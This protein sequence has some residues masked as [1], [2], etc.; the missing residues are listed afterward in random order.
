MAVS[1]P[2]VDN[3]TQTDA[4]AV[5]SGSSFYLAM[6]ILP[7][8]QRDAMYHVYAFC[9][10][11]DDIADGGQPPAERAAALERWRADIDACYAGSP[12]DSLREL[13][14]HIHTFHLQREDFH[15][16]IDGMAMDAQADICAPDEATLDLYC[17]RVA[18]AAGRLSV[19]IFGMQEEQGRDLAHHLG[20]ALQLTNILRD[21][22]E[23][24]GLNRCYLPRELLAREGIAVTDPATIADDPSLPRV[25]ATIAERAKQHFRASDAIMDQCPRIQVR[26]PRIM[27]AVY[28]CLLDRTIDRG[29]DIPRTKVHKPRARLLWILARYAFF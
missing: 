14:R 17:D 25:C 6:R 27:S 24:A 7:A 23:D 29:F 11:V 22:D 28:H 5:T 3:N 20:R 13:T 26:A 10:A 16:M 12:R 8:A 21:I 9:R 18:S 19:R 15:A 4:A 2:V 1:N